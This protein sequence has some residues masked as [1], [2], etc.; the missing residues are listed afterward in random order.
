[1]SRIDSVKSAQNYFSSTKLPVLKVIHRI[2]HFKWFTTIVS[3]QAYKQRSNKSYFIL[4]DQAFKRNM[5]GRVSFHLSPC[6]NYKKISQWSSAN[7]RSIIGTMLWWRKQDKYP[8]LISSFYD[9]A[10]KRKLWL[11]Q[12]T[13]FI[14]WIYGMRT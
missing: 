10:G 5:Y 14:K 12:L 9:R 4:S 2:F 8:E 7:V 1:M 11:S 6:E 13:I 3:D